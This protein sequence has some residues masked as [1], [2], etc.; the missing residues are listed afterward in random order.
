MRSDSSNQCSKDAVQ[1]RDIVSSTKIMDVSRNRK[2]G[3]LFNDSPENGFIK[4]EDK[5][6]ADFVENLLISPFFVKRVSG[7]RIESNKDGCEK[8]LKDHWNINRK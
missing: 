3:Y 6:V 4:F 8:W 7:G 1:E 5:F 2:I